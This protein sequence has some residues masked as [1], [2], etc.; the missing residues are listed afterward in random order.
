MKK[1]LRSSSALAL[2]AALALSGLQ[3]VRAQ[4]SYPRAIPIATCY[5]S[6]PASSTGWASSVCASFT[7][8]G[9]GTS[10]AVTSVTG[11]ILPGMTLAGTGVPA[12][13]TI[14][15]QVS[16]TPGGAGTYTTS[17]ATT[18]NSASLTA[19]GLPSGWASAGS[20]SIPNPS[21]TLNANSAYI[22]AY[23]QAVVWRDD[24]AAPTATPGTGGQGLASGACLPMYYGTLSQFRAIQ[25]TSG[26]I[27]T[28]SFYQ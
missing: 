28:A 20:Q 21:A 7:G 27:L 11:L 17:T 23:T 5:L 13:T 6:S 22:C 15:G 26:A 16:G 9:T 2:S 4:Q 1:L 10:L 3:P 14:T 19:G 24:G 25:Q 8:T 12:G 18:S